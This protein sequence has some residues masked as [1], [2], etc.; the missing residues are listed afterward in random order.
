VIR[1]VFSSVATKTLLAVALIVVLAASLSVGIYLTAFL[2]NQYRPPNQPSPTPTPT[3]EPSLTPQPTT[4]SP[5]VTSKPTQ[6]PK[7]PSYYSPQPTPTPTPPPIG[8]LDDLTD[9]QKVKLQTAS[10]AANGNWSTNFEISP[11]TWTAGA[12]VRIAVALNYSEELL[13]NFKLTYPRVDNSCLL[14]TAE[15]DFDPAGYQ[16]TPW[17]EQVSTILTPAG[18]PIEG[19]GS[20]AISSYTGYTQKTPVDVMVEVPIAN[21]PLDSSGQLYSGKFLTDFTL[22]QNLPPGIYR[23]RLD[24]GF[25]SGSSRYSFN[26]DG[27]GARPKDL[28]NVFSRRPYLQAELTPREN[29]LMVRRLIAEAIGRSFG[30]TTRM[31]IEAS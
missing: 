18:L 11:P 30:I 31:V 26:G 13:S 14:L 9:Q 21:F 2:P 4:P 23:L 8:L 1:L 22:P 16:H 12:K 24:F 29:G 10:H 20:A 19:G 6:Q 25:K 5:I 17:D 7:S 15:R 3:T 27:I 28:N